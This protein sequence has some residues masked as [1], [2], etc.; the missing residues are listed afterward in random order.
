MCVSMC[1]ITR[2]SCPFPP[3]SLAPHYFPSV[4][5]EGSADVAT[6]NTGSHA[7]GQCGPLSSD[8]GPFPVI[9]ISP[10]FILS[11]TSLLTCLY[12]QH[13][14]HMTSA[15]V[16]MEGAGVDCVH[17]LTLASPNPRPLSASSFTGPHVPWK[18]A[19]HRGTLGQV[20]DT[21]SQLAPNPKHCWSG[22]FRLLPSPH[23]CHYLRMN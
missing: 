7:C 2:L 11:C 15:R 23:G 1:V 3:L 6:V 20:Q 4:A 17:Q 10:C 9:P 22:G 21:N 12:V 18:D 8:T 14:S 19:L 13:T 5:M 16:Q